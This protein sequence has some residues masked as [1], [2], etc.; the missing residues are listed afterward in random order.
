MAVEQVDR[1][2][3]ERLG[4]PLDL[5]EVVRDL[6]LRDRRRLG[7]VAAV[8]VHERAHDLDLELGVV[9]RGVPASEHE[10]AGARGGG[11]GG[12]G[13]GAL[14]MSCLSRRGRAYCYLGVASP[15]R[16]VGE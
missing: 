5:D 6:L 11:G 12:G 8:R 7:R 3:R 9:A 15:P 13:G 4:R 14:Y 10:R 2:V 16:P 1:V